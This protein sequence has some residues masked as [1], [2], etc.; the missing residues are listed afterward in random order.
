MS[1][2]FLGILS[3]HWLQK[4][5]SAGVGLPHFLQVVIATSVAL[6]VPRG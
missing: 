6:S 1:P 3:P 5:A 2:S 4:L